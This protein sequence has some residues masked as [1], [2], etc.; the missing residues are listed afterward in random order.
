MTARGLRA[1]R[2]R[3]RGGGAVPWGAL[4]PLAPQAAR[5]GGGGGTLGPFAA[6]WG[7]CSPCCI[8]APCPTTGGLSVGPPGRTD[9]WAALRRRSGNSR[10]QGFEG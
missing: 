1:L 9:L 10:Q 7:F 6:P 5:G 3:G 2:L 4:P 8:F